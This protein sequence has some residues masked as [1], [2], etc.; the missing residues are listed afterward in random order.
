MGFYFQSE[1]HIKMGLD[2]SI[3]RN[4]FVRFKIKQIIEM[5]LGDEKFNKRTLWSIVAC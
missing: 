3:S 1:I 2:D 4:R 5:A